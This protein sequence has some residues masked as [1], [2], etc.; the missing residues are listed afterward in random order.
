MTLAI[1]SSQP[2]EATE[3]TAEAA[4]EGSGAAEGDAV[5]GEDVGPAEASIPEV[6]ERPPT[7]AEPDQPSVGV[8][9]ETSKTED[10]AQANVPPQAT[11]VAA[12]VDPDT[13]DPAAIIR[14]HDGHWGMHFTFG[15]L[16]PMSIAGLND[17]RI[18]RL[19]FSELGVRRAFK[20]GWALPF[21]AGVGWV[22]N[23]PDQGESETDVGL[24]V[25][26][27]V[28]KSFRVWRRI[29]PYTGGDARVTYVDPTGP[30]HFV[31]ISLGPNLGIEYFVADRVSLLLQG[32][33]SVALG[34]S[35]GALQTDVAT[36]VSGGG[37]MGLVFYF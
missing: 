32:D 15:G 7:P 1:S 6:D 16:A 25:S 26:I 27:G 31:T 28:R 35:D 14:P 3:P 19:M 36:H 34:I 23:N 21:S 17:I 11:L 9:A 18:N 12:P 2:V 30:E 29:A 5:P 24:S 4:D 10:D 8:R 37:Q 13:D 22:N 33:F 20:N